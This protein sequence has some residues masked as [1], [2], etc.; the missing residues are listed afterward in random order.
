ME[1]SSRILR[2]PTLHGV[3]NGVGF[4]RGD[5]S[6]FDYEQSVN[7]V[8]LKRGNATDIRGLPAPGSRLPL[9]DPLHR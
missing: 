3:R 1:R 6:A 8:L 2:K 9:G 5:F 7:Q 4:A